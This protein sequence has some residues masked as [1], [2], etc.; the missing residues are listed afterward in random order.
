MRIKTFLILNTMKRQYKKLS[1]SPITVPDGYPPYI[2]NEESDED[3]KD[4][5]TAPKKSSEKEPLI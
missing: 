3:G 5:G 1:L 4:E 2:P